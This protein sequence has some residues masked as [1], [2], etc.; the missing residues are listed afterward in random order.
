M[1][2]D[3]YRKLLVSQDTGSAIKG[4]VRGDVFFGN[5]VNAEKMASSMNHY[6]HYFI[7]LPANLVDKFMNK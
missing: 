5:G 7:L 6:G 3:K 2:G 1:D 4:A